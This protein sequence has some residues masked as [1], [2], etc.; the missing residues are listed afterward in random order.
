VKGQIRL[1]DG[2]TIAFECSNIDD[3]HAPQLPAILFSNS[4]ASDSTIWD[5]VVAALP[6]LRLI[7]YDTRGH[8][9]ST[10][11]ERPAGIDTLGT[12]ALAV[13]DAAGVKRAVVCGLSLGGL[14]AMWLGVHAPE[15]VA[16]LVLANTAASYPPAQMWRDRY[17]TALTEGMAS[18][19]EPTLQRWFKDAFRTAGHPVVQRIASMI[20][21]TDPRGYAECACVLEVADLN[22]SLPQIRCP[23]LVIVGTHDPST[24][25]SR[26]EELVA[27]IPNASMAALDAAHMSCVEDPAG[28]ASLLRDFSLSLKGD[29]VKA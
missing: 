5:A 13:L 2:A 18:I 27:A 4:L 25:P 21:A 23:S 10:L 17:A 3:R 7:R 16:G 9:G 15:R 8:G 14:T 1:G 6:G 29:K 11:G 12:D 22:A 26:G 19:V 24:P 28:F 20:G